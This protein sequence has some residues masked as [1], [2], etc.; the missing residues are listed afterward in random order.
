MK[1]VAITTLRCPRCGAKLLRSFDTDTGK[2]DKICLNC[3]EWRPVEDH[4]AD[5]GEQKSRS[6]R[7]REPN[8]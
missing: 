4:R 2:T 1:R 3:D 6:S 8:R 5:L 7:T